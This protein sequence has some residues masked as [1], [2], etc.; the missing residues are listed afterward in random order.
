[1]FITFAI[2]GARHGQSRPWG[3]GTP[4]ITSPVELLGRVAVTHVQGLPKGGSALCLCRV[5]N[6][7]LIEPG[8]PHHC[9]R[10]AA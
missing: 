10:M 7:R 8:L 3:V 2:E 6:T 1:M 4:I 9:M 5:P